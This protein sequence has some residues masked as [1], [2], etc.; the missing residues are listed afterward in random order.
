MELTQEEQQKM[1]AFFSEAPLE[2]FH[3]NEIITPVHSIYR[4]VYFIE[5]GM[6]RV[7]YHNRKD[8]ETT[9]MFFKENDAVTI[10]SSVYNSS[11]TPYGFQALENNT[12]I[13][14]IAF[15]DFIKRKEES[16]EVSQIFE[17]LLVLSAIRVAN[18]LVAIQIKTAKERYNDLLN[19]NPEIFQRAN[20]GHIA[21]Y[22]GMKQQSLSRIRALKE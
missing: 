7:F 19:Q 22:L 10:L 14:K 12:S 20:L 1:G 6:T 18:Q 2:V 4:H 16:K 17:K 5:K 13:R 21:S 15:S 9:H 8:E 3:K 11:T